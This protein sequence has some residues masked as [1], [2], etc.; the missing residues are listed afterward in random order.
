MRRCFT[1]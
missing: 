1:P